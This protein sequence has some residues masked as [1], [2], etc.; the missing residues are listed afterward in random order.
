MQGAILATQARVV[1]LRLQHVGHQRRP[2]RVRLTEGSTL[3]EDVAASLSIPERIEAESRQFAAQ[4]MQR[5]L[6][7]QLTARTTN[8]ASH[9][10][11]YSDKARRG[12]SSSPLAQ[13][14]AQ[15]DT[16][17]RDVH[18]R[19]M[20]AVVA[21]RNLG[22]DTPPVMPT[23]EA[24]QFRNKEAL[25]FPSSGSRAPAAKSLSLPQRPS[26]RGAGARR[27][28]TE[29]GDAPRSGRGGKASKSASSP[30]GPHMSPAL[31][32]STKAS[33]SAGSQTDR[34]ASRGTAKGGPLTERA[35]SKTAKG[36]GGAAA[37]TRQPSSSTA[38]KA[39]SFTS[40][41]KPRQSQATNPPHQSS[42]HQSTGAVQTSRTSSKPAA[43]TAMPH[44]STAR[45]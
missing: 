23:N 5:I 1:R 38:E 37:S 28:K 41:A 44:A 39:R 7:G 24:L 11:I 19:A 34:V 14:C 30:S 21:A 2:V 42:P 16:D 26:S 20:H 31:G 43:S 4:I 29:R 27:S 32:P 25:R 18:L 10:L 17:L 13:R 9:A 36:G 40:K 35:A 8:R 15:E 22:L 45:E 33:K 6:R 12:R 3:R